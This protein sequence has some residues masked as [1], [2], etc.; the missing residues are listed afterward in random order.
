MKLLTLNTHSLQEE[1]YQ[2]KLEEFVVGILQEKPDIIALQEVNQSMD[3]PLAGEEL[4]IGQFPLSCG[5]PIRKDNHAAQ[6]AYALRQAGI[7]CS[8]AWL[9]IKLGYGKYEEGVAI[10]SLGRTIS[11]VDVCFISK[12]RD[13]HNWCT[14][15]VLGVQTEGKTD[16]FYTV[17][18]GWWEDEEEPFSDQWERLHEHL[19]EKFTKEKIWLMGDFNAPDTVSGQSYACI[20]ASGWM[21][22]YQM[23]QEK[24]SGI[25][26]SGIIDG[27]RE[28][29]K[30]QS[31]AGKISDKEYDRRLFYYEKE[32]WSKTMG[33]SNAGIH[34]CNL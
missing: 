10:L 3:G 6:V 9:P 23:A 22:T 8:W 25:T 13:H 12:T 31:A 7:D 34:H 15:A 17:H 4:R 2:K 18:M 20:L 14:R 26:V 5:R 27:W 32:L 33:I 11:H 28:K 21:D 29:Q 24:D 16:W 19:A 30:E 1:Q